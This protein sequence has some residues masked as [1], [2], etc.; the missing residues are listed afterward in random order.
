MFLKHPRRSKKIGAACIIF[1]EEVRRIVS[2]RQALLAYI[3]HRSLEE[4]NT[5]RFYDVICVFEFR[6]FARRLNYSIIADLKLLINSKM[7]KSPV[8][9]VHKKYL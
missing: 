3:F 2:C 6:S 5:S 9:N 8:G 1:L 4:E 7:I